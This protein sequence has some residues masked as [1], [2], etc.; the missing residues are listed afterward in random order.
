MITFRGISMNAVAYAIS[1]TLFWIALLYRL[2]DLWRNRSASD[3]YVLLSVLLLGATTFTMAVL[4]F[5][6][7]LDH[8]VGIP[9]LAALLTHVLSLTWNAATLSLMARWSQ[10]PRRAQSIASRWMLMCGLAAFALVLLFIIDQTGERS[11]HYIVRN[12]SRPLGAVYLLI[13]VAALATA[14]VATIR[15]CL[16]AARLAKDLWLRRGLRTVVAGS[17]SF[18]LFCFGR[19]FDVVAVPLGFDLRAWEML[20]MLSTVVGAG[21]LAVGL[22]MPSWGPKLSAALT[23]MKDYLDYQRLRPLWYALYCTNPVIALDPPN[24]KMMDWIAPRDLEYRLYRRVIEIRDGILRLCPYYEDRVMTTATT[25][26]KKAGLSGE[27]LAAFVEGAQIMVAVQ[28]SGR[29][30]EPQTVLESRTAGSL[31]GTD[32]SSETTWLLQV[33]HAFVR[34]RKYAD[35]EELARAL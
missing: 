22:T 8:L 19:A 9:N 24:S 20:P 15:I 1:G 18:L 35:G 14:K 2:P 4:M 16:P 30:V 7:S 5:N 6:D 34:F 27:G 26:G 31:G 29:D 21:L 3:L 25:L 23:W 11:D 28:A 13:F 32:I 12:S 17:V 10:R 33:A